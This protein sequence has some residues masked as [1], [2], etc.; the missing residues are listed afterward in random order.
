MNRATYLGP[1]PIGGPTPAR[2]DCVDAG[3]GP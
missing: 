1:C 2:Y 3:T